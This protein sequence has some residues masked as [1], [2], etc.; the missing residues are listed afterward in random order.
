[1]ARLFALGLAVG[2]A[3]PLDHF[4]GNGLVLILFNLVG[5]GPQLGGHD[6]Q[7]LGGGEIEALTRDTDAIV[8]LSSEEFGGR[9]RQGTV[10]STNSTVQGWYGS[11]GAGAPSGMSAA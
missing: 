4:A 3:V 2:R 6:S 10:L 8:R 11:T 9:S 7:A 5:L 1:M